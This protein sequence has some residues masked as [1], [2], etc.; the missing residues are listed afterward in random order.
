[1]NKFVRRAA[2][3]A[4][5]ASAASAATVIALEPLHAA[6]AP[7]RGRAAAPAKQD[8][9]TQVRREV[10]NPVNDSLKLVDSGDFAGALAK[11]QQAD[12]VPMKTPFEEYTVAKYLGNIYIKQMP[13]NL[14]A[15]TVAY[16][17]QVASGA[18]PDAEKPAMYAMALR[19]NYAAKDYSKVIQNVTELKKI[20]GPAVDETAHLV[21]IQSYYETM[22]FKN[23]AQ[24]AKDAAAAATAEGKKPSADVLGL[25]LNS[26]AKIMDEAGYRV[27]LDQL[28]SVS[29]QPDVWGQVMDFALSAK[30]IG[31]H[32][33]HLLNLYRLAM[34]VGTMRDVDYSAMATIDLS[35][36]L[37][38][39][40]KAV[41]TKGGNK[42]AELMSQANTFLAKDQ[43]AITALAG[44]AAKQT[45]GE[46]DVK[47]G[48][49]YLTYAKYNE[50]VDAIQKGIM[51]GGL[52]DLAD[53]QTTLGIA[54][55]G[56]GKK[57]EALAEFEKASKAT[58][59]A[60]Q[61]AHT[62]ALFV[63]RPSA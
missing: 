41:L 8:P 48:E 59:S 7:A 32:E 4:L 57:A 55:Y 45:N 15:A 56:A 27:T 42:S 61:V 18:A 28:A 43:E 2:M 29:T 33:H 19:L 1:M 26:Q 9:A 31:M 46:I 51:K 60:G 25:L 34:I 53:A 14:P 36:Q 5:L 50:A 17:R 37:P 30:D 35:N 16:N 40:A 63:Q 39:E 6:Q 23:A 47:L 13:Q 22:D 24:A 49:S 11:V 3:A 21:L 20:G 10:G 62:W 44:E 58:T 38:N 12:M 54:L 52:M